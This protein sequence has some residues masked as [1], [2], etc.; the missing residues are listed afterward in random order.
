M[1]RWFDI[2]LM[3]SQRRRR[4]LNI[5]T[6]LPDGS[7]VLVVARYWVRIPVE[8]DVCYRGCA[9]TVFQNCSNA[10]SVQCAVY[11]TVHYKEPLK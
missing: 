9:Y 10:W 6:S 5:K 3:L 2:V 4:W 1:I 8:S 7:F 11:G